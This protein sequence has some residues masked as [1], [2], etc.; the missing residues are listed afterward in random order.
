MCVRITTAAGLAAAIGLAACATAVP[1][2]APRT[3]NVTF[4]LTADGQPAR[5]GAPLGRLGAGGTPAVLHDARF[6]VQDVA[7]ID[8]TGKA[9]P[10]ALTDGPWQTAGVGLLDF[11]DGTGACAKGTAGVNAVVTGRVPAGDYAGLAFTVGVPPT[12]NHTSTEKAPAPLDSA[13]MGWSWQA[14]RKFMKVEVDPAGGVARP[15]G[16]NATT[17]YVHLGSTDCAGNPANGE[18]V[19]CGHSNRIPVTFAAFDPVTQAVALDLSSLFE[20]S[21]LTRDKGGPVGR[22]SGPTDPECGLVFGRLGLSKEGTP[23][24][25]GVSPVFSVVAKP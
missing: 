3:V 8:R 2:P 13:A 16:S 10:L 18:S 24:V 9:V 20:G 11:E 1:E 15:D 22:M 17:W 21:V 25:A 23:L 12:L 4:T 7:L 6:Y 5:C 19:S 14:G